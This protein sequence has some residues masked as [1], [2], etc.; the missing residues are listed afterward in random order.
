MKEEFK[1]YF[2]KIQ[3]DK[4]PTN[5]DLE[6]AVVGA[7]KDRAIIYYFIWKTIQDLHPGIDADRI[8]REASVKFGEYKGRKWG[9]VNTAKDAIN[10]QSSKA[11]YLA[12]QQELTEYTD[13]YAQKNF[14]Y[15]PHLDAFKELGCSEEETNKLCQDMLVYGDYGIFS[16]HENVK[17]E[18]PE[19]L[20]K[21]DACCAMCITRVK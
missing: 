16:P 9:E 4:Q 14:K 3:F 21:G 12:F 20:S 17:V 19:Q 18:F 8:M 2:Q 10:A 1:E 6:K 7:V 15:C 13:N 11:G 5:E